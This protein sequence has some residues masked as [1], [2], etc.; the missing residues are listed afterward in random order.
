MN[1]S[2]C[3]TWS[4]GYECFIIPSISVSSWSSISGH[5]KS[6]E[7]LPSKKASISQWGILPAKSSINTQVPIYLNLTGASGLDVCTEQCHLL[8]AVL[9]SLVCCR[10]AM[11]PCRQTRSSLSHPCML[12]WEGTASPVCCSGFQTLQK[13]SKGTASEV[14]LALSVAWMPACPLVLFC[15]IS[16][17][18]S[19]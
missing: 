5:N 10:G 18:D 13:R 9:L 14:G 12:S 19:P 16:L 6:L 4:S 1:L 15:S 11:I 2:R 17:A 3:L 8:S 7:N